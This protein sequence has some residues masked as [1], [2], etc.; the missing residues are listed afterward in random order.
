MAL[1]QIKGKTSWHSLAEKD[2]KNDRCRRA[3]EWLSQ[4]NDSFI[5]KKGLLFFLYYILSL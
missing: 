4:Y 2:D 5:S 1:K 3:V